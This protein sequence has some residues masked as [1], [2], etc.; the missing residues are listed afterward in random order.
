ME[1]WD[2]QRDNPITIEIIG[3]VTTEKS[4]EAGKQMDEG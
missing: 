2:I 3:D 4:L 1:L